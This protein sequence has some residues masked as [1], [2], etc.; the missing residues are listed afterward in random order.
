MTIMKRLVLFISLCLSASAYSS[1]ALFEHTQAVNQAMSALYMQGLSEGNQKYERDL[2]FYKQK[3]STSLDAYSK[4]DPKQAAKLKVSWDN[5]KDVIITTYSRDYGW[6][7][8]AVVRRDLR[9]YQTDLYELAV[10]KKSANPSEQEKYHFALLQLECI[11]ARF[12]DI[13]SNIVGKLSLSNTE[14]KILN[15]V[16]VSN[17][18]KATL[19]SIIDRSNNPGLV[20][21]IISAQYKWEFIEGSVVT[22]S[23]QSA[24]FLVYATKKKIKEVLESGINQISQVAQNDSLS[25]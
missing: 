25:E 18:F 21:S 7:T 3:A 11:V 24:H 14:S 17:E 16:T 2:D 6:D 13:A 8:D 23:D 19:Q 15:P 5:L 12:Y 22:Y 9:D 4:E 1:I 20:K 10:N